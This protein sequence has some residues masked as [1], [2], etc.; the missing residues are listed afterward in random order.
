[1]LSTGSRSRLRVA[2]SKAAI[3]STRALVGAGLIV[4]AALGI[5]VSFEHANAPTKQLFVVARGPLVA[6]HEITADDIA[7]VSMQLP[8]VVSK[9]SFKTSSLVIGNTI[10]ITLARGELIQTSMVSAGN[11]L[12]SRQVVIALDA[13]HALGGTLVANQKVDVVATNGS[14]SGAMTNILLKGTRVL[15]VTTQKQNI[16]SGTTYLVTLA[17][18][19]DSDEVAITNA[20]D[21]GKITLIR[22]T[23]I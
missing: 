18:D 3:P 12:A 9:R 22:T 19:S 20:A 23:G 13:Q 7:L 4:L 1:M 15:A 11:N 6:G 2:A 8:D 14:G 10:N 5:F 21:V 17:L 16:A